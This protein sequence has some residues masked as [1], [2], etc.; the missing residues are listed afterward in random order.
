MQETKEKG[1]V[2]IGCMDSSTPLAIKNV[3][4]AARAGT[5]AVVVEPPFYYP[6]T[7]DEVVSHFSAVAQASALPLVIYNIPPANKINIMTA[8][9]ERLSEVPGIIGIKDSTSDF[10]YLQQLL[11]A[12]PGQGGQKP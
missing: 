1:S 12:F 6:C 5:D 8:L 3:R 11:R 4:L 9:T 7:D 10:I 2:L